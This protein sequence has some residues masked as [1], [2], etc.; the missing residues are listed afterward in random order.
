MTSRG[1]FRLCWRE[2]PTGERNVSVKTIAQDVVA[3]KSPTPKAEKKSPK[4]TANLEM[5]IEALNKKC[6]F[7]FKS[8]EVVVIPTLEKPELDIYS[9]NK[10]NH[11]FDRV[12]DGKSLAH[13]WM[14]SPKRNTVYKVTYVPEGPQYI[15]G[16][17]NTWVPSPIKPKKGD[18]SRF[19]AYI[20]HIFKN[21][22]T[23]KDWF[24]R[25]AA[26][27]IQHPGTKLNTAIVCWSKQTGNGKTTFGLIMRHIYGFH[28]SYKIGQKNLTETHNIWQQRKVFIYGEEI[29]S[30]I[31]DKQADEL[32]PMI[33]G[34]TI[35]INPKHVQQFEIPD[36]IN[37]YF[38]S[39][40]D[41]AFYL[42]EADRRFFVHELP[43]E[44]GSTAFWDDFYAY[45]DNGG[46]EAIYR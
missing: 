40:H 33:T 6:A 15:D 23:H 10:F 29:R 3:K 2:R 45:L 25:W 37:Y 35:V 7:I 42:D 21:D 38:T 11:V 16:N 13:E 8:A 39:N 43:E 36:T 20:D 9:V 44:R 14:K 4:S 17:L 28:N 41:H 19:L 1:L 27:P 31:S 34:D 24:I 30:G 22:P 5:E 32:K 46:D 12:V 26:Y 18:V